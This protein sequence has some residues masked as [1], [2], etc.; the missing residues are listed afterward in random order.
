MHTL[1]WDGLQ[2]VVLEDGVP[3]FRNNE[4]E[5]CE[6]YCAVRGIPLDVSGVEYL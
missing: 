1:D 2:W 3:V 4:R 6:R 5:E